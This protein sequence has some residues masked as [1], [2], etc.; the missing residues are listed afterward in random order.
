MES[1]SRNVWLVVGVGLLLLCCCLMV[2]AVVGVSVFA[3]GMSFVD[4]GGSL[5]VERI[6][7]TFEVGRAPD[8][9]IDNFAGRVTVHAGEGSSIRVIAVKKGPGSGDRIQVTMEEREGGL[10]IKTEKPRGLSSASVDLDITAPPG[11]RLDLDTG[12]GS[13]SVEGIQGGAGVHTGSGSITA[14]DLAGRVKLD[15]GSGS[16]TMEGVRGE[17]DAHTGAGSMEARGAAGRVSLDSGSG[18]I[19]YQGAPAGDCRFETGSGSIT[20]E[21]PADLS[22]EVQ[23]DTGSGTI[24]AGFDVVGT[25]SRKEVEGVVG[26]GSQGSIRA[27]TGAG[28]I[29]LIH[30]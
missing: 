30:R 7:R 4:W 6:E 26:D 3:R 17:I 16:V 14:L 1:H 21:L 13:V 28:S 22:M 24:D 12:A 9:K 18:S 25:V 27:H 23:L 11:T 2:A 20:L 8:L 19:A 29:D 5:A 10:L 15:S